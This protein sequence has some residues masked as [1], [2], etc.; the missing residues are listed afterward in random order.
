MPWGSWSDSCEWEAFS[1]SINC[2]L[3]F[4]FILEDAQRKPPSLAWHLEVPLYSLL[5][6]YGNTRHGAQNQGPVGIPTS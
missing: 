2:I 5:L 3:L 6:V 4:M 1:I